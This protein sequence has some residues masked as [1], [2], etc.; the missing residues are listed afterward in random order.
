MTMHTQQ[1]SKSETEFFQS[2]AIKITDGEYVE[3]DNVYYNL[4]KWYKHIGNDVYEVMDKG[5]LPEEIRETMEDLAFAKS[6]FTKY[7]AI[8][9]GNLNFGFKHH[10]T[11][12]LIEIIQ[13]GRDKV[14]VE[15]TMW[16][17]Y[18]GFIELSK[19]I[20]MLNY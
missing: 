6:T 12:S 9:S 20:A 1:L 3:G 13:Y 16:M 19:F 10:S 18:Y 14:T 8:S 5:E 17:D 15:K 7:A 4:P 2:Q 11:S